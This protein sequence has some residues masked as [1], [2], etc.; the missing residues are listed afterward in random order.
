M[1]QRPARLF[2]LLLLSMA[3][4]GC[5]DSPPGGDGDTDADADGDGDG[6]PECTFNEHCLDDDRCNGVERCE[7]GRCVGGEPI[8]CDSGVDC[9]VDFCD[10]ADGTC[11]ILPDHTRCDDGE[12]CTVTGCVA[13]IPCDEDPDCDD[14]VFCNGVEVCAGGICTSG[15]PPDCDDRIGCTEDS[16]A[17]PLDECVN[18]PVD[19]ACDDGNP[20][21]DDRCAPER[22]ACTHTNNTLL[23][24]D[25]DPCTLGDLCGDGDCRPGRESPCWPGED[26]VD[27]RCV[28][29]WAM[30]CGSCPADMGCG[31]L[32]DWPYTCVARGCPPGLGEAGLC[33]GEV[34]TWCH[35]GFTLAL[36]CEWLYSHGICRVDGSTGVADCFIGPV[37]EPSCREVGC[38][39]LDGCGRPCPCRTGSWCNEEGT[40]VACSCDGRDCG[41]DECGRSCGTCSP[42]QECGSDGRCIDCDCG[43]R[44]CGPDNCGRSCGEMDWRQGGC[45]TGLACVDGTC[46]HPPDC[47]APDFQC[48]AEDVPVRCV[49]GVRYLDPPCRELGP[50]LVC[51][52]GGS[53]YRC[54]SERLADPTGTN[55]LDCPD[56]EPCEPSCAGREC[57]SDG[58]SR[59]CGTCPR[60]TLCREG[61]CEPVD[62]CLLPLAGCCDGTS[63]V[64]CV[65]AR[66]DRFPCGGL[67][68]G[69]NQCGWF[70][71]AAEGSYVCTSGSGVDPTGTHP[72]ECPAACVTP[73]VVSCC[74]PSCDGR[75]C[76]DD[77]CGGSCGECEDGAECNA[78]GRCVVCSCADKECGDDGCGGSCG[79]CGPGTRCDEEGRCEACS[80]DGLS[81]GDDGCGGSC[82]ECSYG[83]YQYCVT[84]D[85]WEITSAPEGGCCVGDWL[86]VLYQDADR[87][88]HTRVDDCAALG[89]HCGWNPAAG[90]YACGASSD[91]APGNRPPQMCT[92]AH[93][94]VPGC[95]SD[96][97]E[98]GDGGCGANC[99]ECTEGTV[100]NRYHRCVPLDECSCG[101]RTCGWPPGGSSCFER[102]GSCPRGQI[103]LDGQCMVGDC[104]TVGTWGCCRED[105]IAIYCRL[106]GDGSAFWESRIC[107]GPGADFDFPCGWEAGDGA[108]YY[109]VP[110]GWEYSTEDPSGVHPR[111]CP[112]FSLACTPECDGRECGSDGCSPSGCGTCAAGQ[113]CTD[114][115]RCCLPDCRGRNCGDDGCGGLCPTLAWFDLGL[116][117]PLRCDA[118]GGNSDACPRCVLPECPE[119]LECRA[120][121][122]MDG[123][124]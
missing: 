69:F 100:C 23:C 80:C 24:D 112:A 78:A 103:C 92:S 85:C 49:D 25:G 122:C 110:P 40:C 94:C 87:R 90:A 105:R 97:W 6:G 32:E 63:A 37:C 21:T 120:G 38:R 95:E 26:C 41:F 79:E 111:E 7:D 82:G 59:F 57:G 3:F 121:L 16:C 12:L 60:G 1:D 33:D 54:G 51:G 17:P 84:N 116:D 77:G 71:G 20:C 101:T 93:R 48:C 4:I 124:P 53:M 86:G 42:D 55:P 19:A 34:L 27:G 45:E 10:P 46:M 106:F 102:C 67:P 64:H 98:C 28:P 73:G 56:L 66:L 81:C 30:D 9:I 104:A 99:G 2:S 96:G 68:E 29:P 123:S 88:W 52:W 15:D 107:S 89:L 70:V 36:D 35:E 75:E 114:E 108:G 72:L 13:G 11:R 39:D 5:D 83:S 65:G 22:G 31:R 14:H 109:C 43:D 115:G 76:G 118:L 44:Q 47:L 8:V 119:G 113:V 61:T 50:D 91:P 18:E 58:C 117:C 74:L 62:E